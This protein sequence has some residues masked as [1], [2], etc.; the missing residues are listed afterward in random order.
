MQAHPHKQAHLHLRRSAHQPL[1]ALPVPP[2]PLPPLPPPPP[3]R[4]TCSSPSL[5][6]A[7]RHTGWSR[8]RKRARSFRQAAGE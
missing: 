6:K 5:K 3:P 7:S 2:A 1:L 4:P 8:R